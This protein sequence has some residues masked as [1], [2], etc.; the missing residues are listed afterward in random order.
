MMKPRFFAAAIQGQGGIYSALRHAFSSRF[1]TIRAFIM[2]PSENEKLTLSVSR[3]ART[4]ENIVRLARKNWQTGEET[5]LY[6]GNFTGGK[7]IRK[8]LPR[9]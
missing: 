8:R 9:D 4:D 5:L 3:D 2:V 7:P 6:N 1:T